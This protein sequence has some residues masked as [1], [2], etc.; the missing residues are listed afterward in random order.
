MNKISN[1]IKFR[2]YANDIRFEEVV[3]DDVVV[4]LISHRRSFY[5][6]MMLLEEQPENMEILP[7]LLTL[8]AKN[9]AKGLALS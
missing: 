6:E 1:F 4:L 7:T 2:R 5:K 3:E 9:I 8:N